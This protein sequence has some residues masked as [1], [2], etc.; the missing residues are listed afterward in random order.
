MTNVEIFFSED[1]EQTEFDVINKEWRGDVWVKIHQNVY[2]ISAFTTLRLQQE[3]N[4][5]VENN[6]F[7]CPDSNLILVKN[8][9]K[10]EIISTVNWL[11][12][13]GYFSEL[14]CLD[15]LDTSTLV[16]VQ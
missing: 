2:R 11:T 8:T 13:Q 5:G 3:F 6:G 15:N 9:S 10:K 16:K 1:S 4:Y 14:K 12:E 7:Y